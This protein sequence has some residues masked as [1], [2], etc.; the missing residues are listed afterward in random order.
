MNFNELGFQLNSPT[1]KLHR[2]NVAARLLGVSRATIY[3]LVRAG[4]LTLV[5]IGLNASGIT[6]ESLRDFV[7]HNIVRSFGE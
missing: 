1:P 5:K 6:D 2:I 4:H 3:R 7:E